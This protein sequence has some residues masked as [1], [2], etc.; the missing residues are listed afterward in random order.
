LS[1]K[2]TDAFI[3]HYGWVK[4][5]ETMQ[6]KQLDFNK[7]WHD[8]AWIE[9]NIAKVEKFDYS[10]IDSLKKFDGTHPKVMEQRIKLKNWIFKYDLTYNKIRL[11][12][13]FKFIMKKYFGLDFNYKNYRIIP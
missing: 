5:P 11:K 3:Y 6:K 8:D 2:K 12:D 7:L 9:N 4:A 13:R 10:R 1:V